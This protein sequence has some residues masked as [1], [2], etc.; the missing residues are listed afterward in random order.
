MGIGGPGH[1]HHERNLCLPTPHRFGWCLGRPG[2]R[3]ARRPMRGAGWCRGLRAFQASR[4]PMTR[5]WHE[6]GE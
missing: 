1:S 4:A 2:L 3:R 6:M 5:E